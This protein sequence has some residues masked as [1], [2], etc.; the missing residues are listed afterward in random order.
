[1]KPAM[2]AH[3]KRNEEYTQLAYGEMKPSNGIVLE[4]PQ[5]L[6]IVRDANENERQSIQTALTDCLSF[7]LGQ[8]LLLSFPS[9]SEWLYSQT[10][11][12][13]NHERNDSYVEETEYRHFWNSA[14]LVA[15]K[16]E[17][18]LGFEFHVAYEKVVKYGGKRRLGY[19]PS[20]F[21][22]LLMMWASYIMHRASCIKT[23]DLGWEEAYEEFKHALLAI[24]YGND[25]QTSH[26]E[27]E[28]AV[29]RRFEIAGLLSSVQR[30]YL[31]AYD[32]IF[33]MTLR[34][35]IRLNISF[36]IYIKV[37]V[38]TKAFLHQFSDLTER[39]LLEERN[40][41]PVPQESLCEAPP[42]DEV[43]IQAR[44]HVVE[45]TR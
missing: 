31:S 4:D 38:S 21:S 5:A 37:F 39:L 27:N 13:A 29:I 1:M 33:S 8:D 16:L 25:D 23:E 20:P 45:L 14:Q 44:A 35:L 36:N 22:H 10:Y 3:T 19:G 42:F 32:P 30:A 15:T 18:F 9:H 2:H 34:Y 11:L 24:I 43:D 12:G 17:V 6:T 26:V 41:P 28:W 7:S 40:P